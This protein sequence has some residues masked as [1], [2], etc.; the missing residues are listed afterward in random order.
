LN[1]A[2]VILECWFVRQKNRHSYEN[3]L[4]AD[5]GG[6]LAGLV[7]TYDGARAR[8]MDEPLER[9]A[10]SLLGTTD[11]RITTEAEPDEFY[12]DTVSVHPD[13]QGRGLGRELIEAACTLAR[14]QGRDRIGLLVETQNVGAQR[15][16]ERLGFVET[17]HRKILGHPYIHRVRAL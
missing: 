12:L 4:I 9:A 7:V 8:E 1:E 16:Y 10:A 11:Y 13:F 15:L 6:I 17:N 5:E 3:T 2:S 14:Q